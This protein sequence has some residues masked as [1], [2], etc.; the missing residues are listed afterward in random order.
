MALVIKILKIL[1]KVYTF[2]NNA[3]RLASYIIETGQGIRDQEIQKLKNTSFS[4][5]AP[6]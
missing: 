1:E 2:N 6:T 5:K 3:N 4:E